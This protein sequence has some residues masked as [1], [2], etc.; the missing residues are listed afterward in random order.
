MVDP[1]KGDNN[2]LST[3]H[4]F[5]IKAHVPAFKAV[6]KLWLLPESHIIHQ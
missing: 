5:D 4:T 6:A 1:E 2:L 3:F